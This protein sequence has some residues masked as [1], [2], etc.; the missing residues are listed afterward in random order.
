[1]APKIRFLFNSGSLLSSASQLAIT[2]SVA[3][4]SEYSSLENKN[5]YSNNGRPYCEVCHKLS[6][7]Y[8]D[9]FSRLT[10]RG[11]NL[12]NNNPPERKTIDVTLIEPAVV[13]WGFN[14]NQ[15]SCN[16]DQQT[17]E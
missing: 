8:V 16:R 11:R 7:R 5:S 9:D 17:H 14:K 15:R 1:M 6:C 4:E 2:N 13:G 10:R 3:V 12:L